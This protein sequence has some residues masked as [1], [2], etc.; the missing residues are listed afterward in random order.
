MTVIL[1]LVFQTKLRK[2]SVEE[3]AIQHVLGSHITVPTVCRAAD[4]S[5]ICISDM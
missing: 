4:I 2:I 5:E 3:S 1:P